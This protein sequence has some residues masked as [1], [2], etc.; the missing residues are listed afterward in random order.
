MRVYAR[1]PVRLLVRVNWSTIFLG[2]HSHLLYSTNASREKSLAHRFVFSSVTWSVCLGRKQEYRGGHTRTGS[3]AGR[4][5]ELFLSPAVCVRVVVAVREAFQSR[6]ARGIGIT[7]GC[8]LHAVQLCVVCCSA[9]CSG[10]RHIAASPRRGSCDTKSR[11]LC[12]NTG[13]IVVRSRE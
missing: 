12:L 9:L 3:F 13:A 5:H 11:Q 10:V 8:P 6:A 7:H 2:D 1:G 4:A